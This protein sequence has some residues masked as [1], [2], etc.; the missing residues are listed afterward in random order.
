MQMILHLKIFEIYMEENE[1]IKVDIYGKKCIK[2]R[3]VN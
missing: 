2:E 1:E 3:N